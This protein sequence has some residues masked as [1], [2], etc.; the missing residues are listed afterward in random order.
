MAPPLKRIQT[1]KQGCFTATTCPHC[2]VPLEY[3]SP[4]SQTAPDEFELECAVCRKVW[5]AKEGRKDGG[6][7]GANGQP[8]GKRDKPVSGK[9]KIGTDERPLETEYYDLLGLPITCTA[10]DV[11]K[12]YRRLAIK[13]HPDKNPDDPTAADRF[14]EIA[15][16]YTTLSDPKLRKQYNEFGKSK[17]DGGSADEAVDPEVI[18]STLFGGERF[19]D[20]IGTISLGSEMKSAMQ[21]DESDDEDESS[22][23]SSTAVSSTSTS[24]TAATK[25][26]KKPLT[27]EQERR[28][29]LKAE[30]E[31]KLAA[32]K[33]KV[34]EERV[35]V[36]SDKLRDK[37][38]LYAEQ[39]QG[40]EDK[41]IADGVRTMWSIE[42]EELKKESYGVELLQAVGVVYQMK[43]KHYLASTGP[44]PFGIGGWFHA[45]KSTAHIF[46]QTVSTV[47][48]AY[49]LKDVYEEIQKAEQ[50]GTLSEEEK[51]KLEDK[52]AQ[53]GLH[54]LFKGAK[55]EVE[56]IIREV[57]D[58]LL[59]TLAPEEAKTVSPALLR[60]RAVALG[61]LGEVYASV[62]K[63]P[64]MP[65][66][67]FGAFGFAAGS[68]PPG[69]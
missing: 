19:Q 24:S 33:Q 29:A 54:A 2:S 3:L 60:K 42:A 5:T 8:Q 41:Q 46:N 35:K 38:A 32:E 40:E 37:L 69:A 15:V 65:D 4:P 31:A 34:R 66:G 48:S 25:R 58:R 1:H 47:R 57:C 10:E 12:A 63:D 21:L 22:P 16:A 43:S 9:R 30:Q 64:G 51:R 14:K 62:K 13:Y 18:F 6:V 39:A 68:P 11:K 23:S 49:A 44:V 55:L 61:I 17:K 67:P 50:S 26:T 53:M 36:L 28:R 27:P 56:S 7:A 52:A 45:A 20:I 59:T